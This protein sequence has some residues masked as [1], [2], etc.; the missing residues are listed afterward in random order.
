M[1]KTCIA[2]TLLI[3][4]AN[5]NGQP[6]KQPR[7]VVEAYRVATEFQRLFAEDLDFER[8]YEATFT[9]D[10]IKRRAIAIAESELG[11]VSVEAV[12]D[13]TLIG[14]YK[15]QMQI[16]LSMLP[17]VSPANNSQEALFFPPEIKKIFERKRPEA[18]DQ[19]P[20]YAAQL[21]LDADRLR[22]HLKQL[23]TQHAFVAERVRKFKEDLLL[24]RLEPPAD[25]VVKPLTAYSKGRVLRVDEEYYRVGEYAVIREH[26]EMRIIGIRL[27]S[28][29]F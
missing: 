3:L 9:K 22:A 14:I 5:V 8:A 27:F 23:A 12:D 11:S 29:L 1:I 21:K 18:P 20:A 13:A 19:L 15:N 7:E 2:L 28:R 25:H 6:V 10:P 24:Q 4:V 17:L 16:F 26:G